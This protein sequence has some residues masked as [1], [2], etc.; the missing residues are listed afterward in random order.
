MNAVITF[1]G[2]GPRSLRTSGY[3]AQAASERRLRS[4]VL[5]YRQLVARNLRRLGVAPSDVDD[6]TQRVFLVVARKMDVIEAGSER[7]YLL[8]IASRIAWEVRRVEA[9]RQR[10]EVSLETE[11]DAES[12][13]RTDELLELKRTRVLLDRLLSAMPRELTTVFLLSEGEGLTAQ[14]ISRH[15]GIPVGTVASRLRRARSLFHRHVSRLSAP[16]GSA[17]SVRAGECYAAAN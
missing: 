5:E 8:G 9:R 14:E 16:E 11:T 1:P 6:A 3:A 7:A 17:R 13:T 15:L 4:L 12:D 10:R 2:H